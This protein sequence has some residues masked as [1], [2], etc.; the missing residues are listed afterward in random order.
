MGIVWRLMET[1][2][3]KDQTD[4]V[5]KWCRIF[6]RYVFDRGKL[7]FNWEN[8]IVI[9]YFGLKIEKIILN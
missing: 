7:R 6:V 9:G 8:W 5:V 4:S 2:W 1:C 3:V